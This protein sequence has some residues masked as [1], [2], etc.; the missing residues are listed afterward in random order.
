MAGKS[1][2]PLPFLN[3]W[4]HRAQ[5]KSLKGFKP[6]V[7]WQLQLTPLVRQWCTCLLAGTCQL[8]KISAVHLSWQDSV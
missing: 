5:G 3:N 8:V 6:L 1:Q 2:Y 7:D 4:W